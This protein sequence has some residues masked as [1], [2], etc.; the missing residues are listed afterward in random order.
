MRKA[1]V[2]TLRIIK[3]ADKLQIKNSE[4]K[5]KEEAFKARP[6]HRSRSI[7][8]KIYAKENKNARKMK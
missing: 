5:F 3:L 2:T 4:D 1:K 7:I 6:I 8:H